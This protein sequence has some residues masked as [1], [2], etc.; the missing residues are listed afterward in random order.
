MQLAPGP[1]LVRG[2][3]LCDMPLAVAHHLQTRRVDH[4]M[5]RTV[6][7][8]CEL[9]NRGRL[10]PAGESGVVHP[11]RVVVPRARP[12]RRMSEARK[13]S[14][15]RSG[16]WYTVRSVNA[17]MIAR[18]STPDRVLALTPWKPVRWRVP[19]GHGLFVEPD[20]DVA[21]LAERGF[22]GGPVLDSVLRLYTV[23]R[24]SAGF[25]SSSWRPYPAP[26][27]SEDE[28]TIAPARTRGNRSRAPR[29]CIG[30]R[31]AAE[32]RWR[33]PGNLQSRSL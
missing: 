32:R 25:C 19:R 12:I 21:P 1:P 10:A 29:P 28:S 33:G 8:G 23:C 2:L 3:V 6:R 9:R 5:D 31:C 13:P 15:C 26:P 30:A 16:R 22:V 20:R 11:D 7:R 27:S 24:T 18:C 4:E 17:V 14:V